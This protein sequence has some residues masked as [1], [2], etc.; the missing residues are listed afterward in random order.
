MGTGNHLPEDQFARGAYYEVRDYKSRW[1]Q[2]KMRR[3][4]GDVDA[5]ASDELGWVTHEAELPQFREQI[6]FAISEGILTAEMVMAAEAVIAWGDNLRQL[7]RAHLDNQNQ[8]NE[9]FA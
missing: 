9:E 5:F 8:S 4:H 1:R 6:D 2:D 3:F 7:I